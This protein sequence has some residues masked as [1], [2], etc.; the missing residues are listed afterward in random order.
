MRKPILVTMVTLALLATAC[1]GTG[2]EGDVSIDTDH[3]RPEV[4]F[5]GS[6]SGI[7]ALA[8]ARGHVRFQQPG[9]VPSR[10][11][12]VLYSASNDGVTTTLLKL[13]PATGAEVAR[14]TIPGV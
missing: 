10:D 3:A 1:G 2:G 7:T 8:P 6:A 9:A 4:L 5:L 13:D 11:W 14:R 12:S